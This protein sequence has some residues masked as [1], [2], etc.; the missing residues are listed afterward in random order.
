MMADRDTEGVFMEDL[1]GAE[2]IMRRFHEMGVKNCLDDFGTG[3]SSLSYLRRLPLDTIKIDK[4]FVVDLPHDPD[5]TSI[6]TAIIAM[7]KSLNFKVVA[8]SVETQEQLEFLRRH[9]CDLIQG[10]LY[11][12]P[13]PTAEFGLLLQEDKQLE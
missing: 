12:K 9:Q 13:L 3:Y 8:E 6:A 4:S 1:Q 10:Y 5:A 7:A 2:E 11:S